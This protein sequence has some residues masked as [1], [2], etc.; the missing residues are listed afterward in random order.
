[1]GGGARKRGARDD[2]SKKLHPSPPTPDDPPPLLPLILV[3]RSKSCIYYR[4]SSLLLLV[5]PTRGCDGTVYAHFI[6]HIRMCNCDQPRLHPPTIYPRRA[7]TIDPAF[8]DLELPR[9]HL[10]HAR[11]VLS[12][13]DDVD[14]CFSARPKKTKNS[15]TRVRYRI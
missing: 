1:M 14:I 2:I 11:P 6:T 12:P 7:S 9:L 3:V 15:N 8:Y 4:L 5:L 13:R 10:N